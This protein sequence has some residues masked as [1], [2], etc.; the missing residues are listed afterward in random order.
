MT[1]QAWDARAGNRAYF[2]D[3][4]RTFMIFL[5]VLFHAGVVYESS[6][7]GA[8]FWIV[9][10]PST[11]DLVGI[12]NLILDIF[13]MS[14]MFF[15][16]GYLTPRSLESKTRWEFLR[17]RFKRLMV[18]WIVAVFT[19]MPLYKAIFLYSRDLPQEAWTSYFHFSNGIL[20]Q[21]WLW[22][23]PVLFLF[24]LLYAALSSRDWVPARMSFKRG[25]VAAFVI[26]LGTSVGMDM[27]G[28]FGWTT[29]AL[30]DFQNERLLIYFLMF[31]LG[32]LGWRQEIF[33]SRPKSKKL[34]IAVNA[35]AWIPV[36]VYL[37]LLI[38]RLL[39]P[40]I[41]MISPFVDSLILRLSF[42]LSLLCLVYATIE[43]FRF[44]VDR[45]GRTWSELN[46][47]SYYV[48]IIHVIVLGGIALAM[49]D[50]TL[51]SLSKYAILTVSTYV[52]SNVIISLARRAVGATMRI[53]GA[54][55]TAR[56]A[57]AAV[58]PRTS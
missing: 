28:A 56:S 39:N 52:A 14:T 57:P 54:G 51:P 43:T 7:I 30:I 31:T 9:D 47:N 15:I 24:N 37:V 33:A 8:L 4:L 50:A 25:V 10:D 2:L 41:V 49:L 55:A 58:T 36:S 23:L 26:S 29:T 35:T 18:P 34:Y 20:S 19:L 42:C 53:Y 27:L 45:P 22:F 40:G 5:V 48:Y 13:V 17:T 44:F 12:L 21:S 1:E 11:N 16:S 6:G 46:N 38:I 32:S 3:N